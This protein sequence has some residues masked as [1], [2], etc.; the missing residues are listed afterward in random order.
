MKDYSMLPPYKSFL[1]NLL[2]GNHKNCSAIAFDYLKQGNSI[3]MLYED[4]FRNSLYRIGELWEHNKISVAT[5]HL[6]SAIVESIINELY[7]KIASYNSVDKKVIT[8]CVENEYH[9]IGI[10]M[11][12]DIFEMRK[13]NTHFLGANMPTKDI[14]DFISI[15]KP[16][17]L[18]ISISLYF[19]LPSLI[20]MI[21]EIREH[22][23][24]L[25]I[26]IGG[27]AFLHG[28]LEVFSEDSNIAY[29]SN[30]QEVDKY[31]NQF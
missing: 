6:S 26:I 16:D 17:V 4:I 12:N 20:S 8:C 22:Y 7:E 1:D 3:K 24:S 31:I 2:I 30:T 14:I 10:K 19:N 21:Y 25:P 11:V 5:E 9:Q 13:W 18:A 23:K 15:I 28:G 29:L 27:Q